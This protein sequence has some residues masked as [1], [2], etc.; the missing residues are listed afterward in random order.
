MKKIF[1]FSIL[2]ILALFAAVIYFSINFTAS[3]SGQVA[4]TQ[5]AAPR[6]N[7][8][9][10]PHHDVAASLTDQT[11]AQVSQT[12]KPTVI[13]VLSPNHF[14]PQSPTFTTANSLANF[15]LNTDIIS[16]LVT[17]QSFLVDNHLLSQEHGQFVPI[18]HLSQFFPHSTFV[19]IAVSTRYTP[20]KLSDLAN[21]LTAHLP[22]D[23]LYVASVDFA[24]NLMVQPA[25]ENN[26]KSAAIITSFNYSQLLSLDDHYMD[27]PRAIAV[28]M[29]TMQNLHATN[30]Q[31]YY[32]SHSALVIGD[33]SIQGTSYLIGSFSQ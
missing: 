16:A 28:L 5:Q 20:D 12:T 31:Q 22:S 17:D 30:W 9:I 1:F 15:P 27:S 23:T 8:L 14:A 11:L 26:Q 25:L 3:Q 19:P 6:I 13:V 24:H 29:H 32:S 21:Y 7:G 4:G 18:K 10:I 2:S 33:P